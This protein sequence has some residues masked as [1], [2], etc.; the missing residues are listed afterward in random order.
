MNNLQFWKTFLLFMEVFVDCT[1]DMGQTCGSCQDFNFRKI[2]LVTS[3][4]QLVSTGPIKKICN[5]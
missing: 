3:Y 5:I 4:R 1:I 2:S